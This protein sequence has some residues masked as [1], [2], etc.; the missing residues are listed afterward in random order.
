MQGC[1]MMN[2]EQENCEKQQQESVIQLV[3][4]SNANSPISFSQ[5]VPVADCRRNY[6]D[7]MST[8][9]RQQ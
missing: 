7:H 8:V 2:G 6:L 4:V 1:Y 5:P 9:A 3:T